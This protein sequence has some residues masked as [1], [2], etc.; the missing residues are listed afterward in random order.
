MVLLFSSKTGLANTFLFAPFPQ[1]DRILAAGAFDTVLCMDERLFFLVLQRRA[2]FQ[3]TLVRGSPASVYPREHLQ[4]ASHSL[5]YVRHLS[6]TCKLFP[7]TATSFRRARY[8]VLGLVTA[9]PPLL[10]VVCRRAYCGLTGPVNQRR[11]ASE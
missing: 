5:A 9:L 11:V 8:S 6:T 4:Q 2:V 1:V 3:S 10:S 7:T